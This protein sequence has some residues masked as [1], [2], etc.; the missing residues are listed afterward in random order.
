MFFRRWYI[1][2]YLCIYKN[3]VW[4]IEELEKRWSLKV[5]VLYIF[6]PL[7]QQYN[8]IG[9]ILGFFYRS[10]KITFISFIYLFIILGAIIS[11]LLWALIIPFMIFKAIN[12]SI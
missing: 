8:I 7:Y 5:N 9:F 11:Y 2:G 1:N 10:I 6:K 12:P 4:I 3:T